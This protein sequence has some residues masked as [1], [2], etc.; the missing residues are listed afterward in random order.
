M[1]TCKLCANLKMGAERYAP[2]MCC[3]LVMCETFE[4]FFKSLFLNFFHA[5]KKSCKFK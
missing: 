4:F 1:R 5:I 2:L 3:Q